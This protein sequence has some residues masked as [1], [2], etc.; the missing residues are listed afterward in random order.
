MTPFQVRRKDTAGFAQVW[1]KNGV[2]IAIGDVY[3]DFATD[4]ANVVLRNFVATA[5]EQARRL[6]AAA[7]APKIVLAE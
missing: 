6:R 7:Q 1:T 3:L 5:E 4:F 2:A